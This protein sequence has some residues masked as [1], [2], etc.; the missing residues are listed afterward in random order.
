LYAY[1]V[2]VFMFW[3]T[4]AGNHI[5]GQSIHQVSN[6]RRVLRPAAWAGYSFTDMG[7]CWA[8]EYVLV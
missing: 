7:Q 5:V 1:R 4:A 2:R 3:Y 6:Y 8:W